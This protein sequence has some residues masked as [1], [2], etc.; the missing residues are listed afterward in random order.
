[1]KN[2]CSIFSIAIVAFLSGCRMFCPQTPQDALAEGLKSEGFWT[3]VHAAEHMIDVDINKA[4]IEAIFLADEKANPEEPFSRVGRH[5]VLIRLGNN[6]EDRLLKLHEIAFNAESE[7]RIHAIETL[8]KL[9]WQAKGED[10]AALLAIRNDKS[11]DD[12]L[13]YFSAWIPD[14]NDSARELFLTSGFIDS[15]KPHYNAIRGMGG[16]KFMKE[17]TSE[18]TYIILQM[19]ANNVSYNGSIR[20]SAAE[21]LLRDKKMTFEEAQKLYLSMEKD[22]GAKGQYC[23]ILALF[24]P[25]E[26]AE[27]E[28]KKFL[29]SSDLELRMSAAWGLFKL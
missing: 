21:I 9:G 13:R 19:V 26:L 27:I 17:I 24:A 2:F 28:L 22:N 25:K 23:R 8:G 1:M 16:L 3:R 10:E 15:T 18:Q 7:D 6:V 14:T 5:R 29:Q 4:E 11:L 12:G 20:L